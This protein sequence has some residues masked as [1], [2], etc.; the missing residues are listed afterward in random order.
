MVILPLSPWSG[1]FGGGHRPQRGARGRM[2][3][4]HPAQ[5]ELVISAQLETSTSVQ[6]CVPD[7][8]G[9]PRDGGEGRRNPPARQIYPRYSSCLDVL[10]PGTE[11][12]VVVLA[13]SWA[14]LPKA[15]LPD[16]DFSTGHPRLRAPQKVESTRS[17]CKANGAGPAGSLVGF[18]FLLDRDLPSKNCPTRV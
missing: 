11:F 1:R 4:G 7:F 8:R 12:R 3:W 13:S 18:G 10:Q 17:T 9:R 2:G 6:M 5:N 14:F 15:L 16:P